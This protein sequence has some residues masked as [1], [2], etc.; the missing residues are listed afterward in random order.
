VVALVAE[1][2]HELG[3]QGL[4]EQSFL[5]PLAP[6]AARAIW[7]AWSIWPWL[8]T[9]PVSCTSPLTVATLMSKLLMSGSASSADLTLV[10][11]TASSTSVPTVEGRLRRHRRRRVGRLVAADQ[12]RWW[13]DGQGAAQQQA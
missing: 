5:T 3:R 2:A 4:V 9:M 11:M 8:L 1:H 7:A 12:Q 6:S 13:R 10:V